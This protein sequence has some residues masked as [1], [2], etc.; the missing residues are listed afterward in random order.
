MVVA[1]IPVTFTD[2]STGNV[3][4]SWNFGDGTPNVTGK[5]VSHTYNT[6][7]TY[8]V[9]LTITSQTGSSMNC[10]KD[11]VVTAPTTGTLNIS[12]TPAGAEIFI[13]NQDQGKVTPQVIKNIPAGSHQ[14]RLTLSGY[15][16]YSTAFTITAGATTTLNPTLTHLMNCSF[17]Y[18][19]A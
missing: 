5:S 18:S 3:S 15:E 16:P 1:L 14:L 10:F 7:G 17:S 19:Q 4:S 2:T 8:R 6:A 13:D 11:V 9:T 12:S